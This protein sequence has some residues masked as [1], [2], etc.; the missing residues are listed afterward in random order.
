MTGENL[1]LRPAGAL[2]GP[3]DALVGIDL[4]RLPALVAVA[5]ERAGVRFLELFAST[6]R[7]PHTRRAYAR[8]ATDFMAWCEDRGVSSIAAVQP[9]HVAAWIEGKTQTHAALTIK[10]QLAAIR[11]L[12][13]WLVMARS[14]H[15]TRLRPCA[16][17]RTARE[18]GKHQCWI[19]PRHGRC[20]TASTLPRRSA[21][22]TGR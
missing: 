17:R 20:S 7:N 2:V 10:Q 13:D 4:V 18:R 12:F 22:A 19:R 3:D 11:H 9:L 15:S 5:V 14:R 8:A 1:V 21:C 16:G 6:I